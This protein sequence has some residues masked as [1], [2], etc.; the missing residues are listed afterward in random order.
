MAKLVEIINDR[1]AIVE[2][3]DDDRI[4]CVS[5]TSELYDFSAYLWF[6][7]YLESCLFLR[8]EEEDKELNKMMKNFS[9]Y[10][11]L[12]HRPSDPHPHMFLALLTLDSV[13]TAVYLAYKWVIS[14]FPLYI[15]YLSN[16]VETFEVKIMNK[17]LDF[18][19]RFNYRLN[20]RL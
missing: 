16:W 15:L 19:I 4:R 17:H 13:V 18:I 14:E 2:S 6:W 5:D 7:S 8:E 10:L 11:W 1:N 9:E 20:Y 3:L 12:L